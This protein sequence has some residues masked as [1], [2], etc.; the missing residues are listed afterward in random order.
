MR[1]REVEHFVLT[2][3]SPARDKRCITLRAET[4][5]ES[6][7]RVDDC[8]SGVGENRALR[9]RNDGF[10]P[11]TKH[12]GWIGPV[13]DRQDSGQEVELDCFVVEMT[14]SMGELGRAEPNPR[15]SPVVSLLGG[16]RA[17]DTDGHRRG[18]V[19]LGI[20]GASQRLLEK[21]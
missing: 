17:L 7:E 9:D 14:T 1:C 4:V 2:H 5:K 12:C 21:L 15:C 11:A 20:G 16:D 18:V 13:H 6:C 10:G 19:V 8:S 3:G